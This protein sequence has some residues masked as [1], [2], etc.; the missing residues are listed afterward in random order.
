MRKSSGEDH[1]QQQ[2][3]SY[4]HW[5][6]VVWVTVPGNTRVWTASPALLAAL[7]CYNSREGSAC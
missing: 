6:R 7:L 2:R 3:S 5:F 4:R 1:V